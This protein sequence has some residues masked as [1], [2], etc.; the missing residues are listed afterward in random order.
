M[1]CREPQEV[2]VAGQDSGRGEQTE[3]ARASVLLQS[4]ERDGGIQ[5]GW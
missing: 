3:T 2:I 1:H 4:A 5:R